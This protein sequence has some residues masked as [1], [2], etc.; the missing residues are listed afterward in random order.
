MAGV[1]L[2]ISVM[3]CWLLRALAQLSRPGEHHFASEDAET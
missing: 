2:G 1:G 3:V